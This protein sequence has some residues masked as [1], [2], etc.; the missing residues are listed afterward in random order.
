MVR[1]GK[2]FC[3]DS[4]AVFYVSSHLAFGK[5]SVF[6]Q[7]IFSADNFNFGLFICMTDADR[8]I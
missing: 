6:N 4:C 8:M 7:L 3:F 5:A 2:C 1:K